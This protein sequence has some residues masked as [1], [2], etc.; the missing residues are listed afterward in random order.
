MEQWQVP[1]AAIAIVRDDRLLYLKGFGVQELGKPASVTPDTIFPLA[2]CTKPLM[3]TVLAMLVDDGKLDWDDPVR[4]HLPWFKLKDP[5]ADANVTIRDLLTHRTG[6]GRHEALW[7]R[8]PWTVEERIRRLAFLEPTFPFRSTFSYQATAYGAAGFAGAKAAGTT[9]QEL[10]EKRLFGPVGMKAATAIFPGGTKADLASPHKRTAKGVV[11]IERYPLDQLDP[12]GSIH[13]SARD[14][15]KF[16]R[17]QLSGGLWEQRRLL[18]ADSLAEIHLPQIVIRPE[19]LSRAM[20]PHTNVLTYTLGWIA[21]DYRGRWILT[22][23]GTVDGFRVQLTL[24]PEQRL[25]IALFNNLDRTWMNLA[26]TNTLIDRFCLIPAKD[27]NEYFQRLHKQHE[28]GTRAALA[29]Q[30]GA[31]KPNTQPTAPLDAYAGTYADPA[32][33]ECRIR[34]VNHKLHWEWGK[35]QSPLEH[36]HFDTF[37]GTVEPVDTAAFVFHVNKQGTVESLRV[38]DRPFRRQP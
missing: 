35:V 12:A 13:A 5:W 22:H 3:A 18:S 16:L 1:G 6:L 15:S 23:G 10:L 4:K 19:P 25:G 14:L 7:Y 27:W 33:G 26:L 36:F 28:Q 8:S 9:W 29:A 11:V 20:N 17:L 32:Y 37:V 38:F 34:V 21:Q 2:S 30:L 31:R 24:V